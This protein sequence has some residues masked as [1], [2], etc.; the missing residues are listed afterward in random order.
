VHRKCH[1]THLWLLQLLLVLSHWC[2]LLHH[3][4]QVL[5]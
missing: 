2:L 1:L 3:L 4:L 5:L